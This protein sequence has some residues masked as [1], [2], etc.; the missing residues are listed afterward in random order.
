MKIGKAEEEKGPV[1]N[2]YANPM[3]PDKEEQLLNYQ[4]TFGRWTE[5]CKEYDFNADQDNPEDNESQN[6]KV[7]D[8]DNNNSDD[9][10]EDDDDY[11][12]SENE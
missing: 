1:V 8:N 12:E 6:D 10:N 5:I 2:K 11:Y 3:I 9:M 7:V 4:E